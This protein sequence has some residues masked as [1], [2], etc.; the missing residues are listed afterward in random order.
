MEPNTFNFGVALNELKSGQKV[1]RKGWNGK[2]MWLALQVPDANSKMTLP[3]IYIEYPEGHPAYPMGSRVPW[4]ASQ[5][6]LL[7][8]DWI[9]PNF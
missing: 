9:T 8:E 2:G 7:S 3:Y 5:T 1:A 4:L 6:D